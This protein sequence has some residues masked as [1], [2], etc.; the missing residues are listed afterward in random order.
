M[1]GEELSRRQNHPRHPVVCERLL[2]QAFCQSQS[3]PKREPR[4]DHRFALTL[5]PP[6]ASCRPSPPAPRAARWR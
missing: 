5:G 1:H 4:L 2:A 3:R 6:Y